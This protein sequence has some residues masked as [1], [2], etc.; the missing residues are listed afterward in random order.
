MFLRSAAPVSSITIRFGVL[1]ACALGAPMVVAQSTVPFS[2]VHTIAAATTAV[3]QEFTFSVS[4]AGNYT[5]TLTDLGAAL[6]PAAPLASVELAVSTGLTLVGVPLAGAGTLTLNGLAAG[7]YVL[8]VVGT[9]GTAPGSGPFGVEVENAAQAQ[10]AAFQGTLALPSGA[11]PN[12]LAVLNDSFTVTS[13]SGGPCA[14][15]QTG[16]CFTVSLNDLQLPQSLASVTLLLIAQ[17]GA[18]PVAILPNNGVYQASV[19]LTAGTT[20]RIFAAGQAGA[21]NAGLYSVVVVPT[22]GSVPVYGRTVPVGTTMAVGTPTATAGSGVFTLTDLQ[23]PA[24]L[25]SLAAVVTL[26]GQVVGQLNASG[27]MSFT[28]T[29]G[30]YD[31]FAAATPIAAAPAAGSYALELAPTSGAPWLSIG[32]GVTGAGSALSAYSFDAIIP[33]AGSY[34]VSLTDFRFPAP[35]ASARMAVVQGGALLGTPLASTGSLSV[36][37]A[38]GPLSAVIFAQAQS[39]GSLFG[40]DAASGTATAVLDAT[41]AVGAIFNAQQLSITA[42]GS[43]SVT[44]TDLG[45][46]AVF[47]NYDTI[48]TRGSSVVGLIY[49]GGTFNFQATPGTYWIS[50][51]AQP[52]APANAG[53]YALSVGT[54][55]APPIVSLSTDHT[56]VTS[57]NT[58]DI[59]WSSQNAT[60]CSASGGWSG[61][62]AVSGTATSAA[63]TTNT[64]FTLAC[65]GAGG[66]SSKSVTVSIAAASSGGG[67][68]LSPEWL[69]ALAGLLLLRSR[70]LGGASARTS[71]PRQRRI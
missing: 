59:I 5:V 45:F 55:P 9:P 42:A 21:A 35:L 50:F 3:P 32:R 43:Y 10:I 27:S 15:P 44:A 20:Y 13:G 46:P 52:A 18:T 57:G 64:T 34:T 19:P 26:T 29:A 61:T 16:Q 48:V 14:P 12:G 23:Y 66:S 30:T 25:T 38:Q 65:T 54:A 68:A 33:G 67:G 31:V 47:A 51:L 62:K 69:V 49:G 70:R 37:A 36:S 4:T 17:G 41:Q 6:T 39:G 11:L 56:Q 24:A 53:T 58:V 8:H 1:L 22:G 2:E 28:A 63:L 71:L 40:V 7:T 60:A